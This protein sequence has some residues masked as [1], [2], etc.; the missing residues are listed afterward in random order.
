MRRHTDP[1]PGSLACPH[2]LLALLQELAKLR[3][4]TARLH[5]FP[6]VI[7]FEAAFGACALDLS[8]HGRG[9]RLPWDSHFRSQLLPAQA[10]AN[11]IKYAG[12]EQ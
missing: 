4:H 3:R 7:T 8:S 11:A 9:G 5:G 6:V 12:E 1:V 10:Q 2:D